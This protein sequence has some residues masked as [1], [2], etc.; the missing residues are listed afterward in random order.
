[1]PQGM[2]ET[3]SDRG[4]RSAASKQAIFTTEAERGTQRSTAASAVRTGRNHYFTEWIARLH[5]PTA[6][7]ARHHF[8]L[9]SVVKTVSFLKRAT[10]W[11]G[12]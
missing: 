5:P 1:M 12:R 7:Y 6:P 10:I 8:F 4:V 9:V 11:Y 2:S 3:V